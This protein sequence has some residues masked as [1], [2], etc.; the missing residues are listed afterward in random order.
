[1]FKNIGRVTKGITVRQVAIVIVMSFVGLSLASRWTGYFPIKPFFLVFGVI[2]SVGILIL[3][4]Y[5][6]SKYYRRLRGIGSISRQIQSRK[7]FEDAEQRVKEEPEKIKPL[8]DLA[9]IKLESY[10]DRNLK[11][12]TYIFWLCTSVMIIGFIIIAFGIILAMQSPDKPLVSLITG[13]SGVV[14]EL[15]GATFLFVYRST[16]QQAL[17]YTKTLERFNSAGMAM[18]ILDSIPDD[19]QS[20]SLRN[21]TK[22]AVAQMLVKQSFNIE[23]IQPTQKENKDNSKS[24]V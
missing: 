23:D 9:S 1:M 8:W 2:M 7:I 22:A 17:S 13:V 15:I 12:V 24:E 4:I 11:Q 21:S 19:A 14:T 10:I 16:M 3:I 20:D 18:Y 6:E 5:Y